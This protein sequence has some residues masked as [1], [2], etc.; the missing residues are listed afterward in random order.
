MGQSEKLD[1]LIPQLYATLELPLVFDADALNALARTSHAFPAPAGPRVLTPHSGEF[2]RL[3]G[4]GTKPADRTRLAE[5]MADRLDVIMVLKGHRTLVTDGTRSFHN[6]TGNPGMATGGSG[7]V[8]TGIITAL[9]CQGL[10]PWDAACLGVHAH[11]LAGD[12]AAESC[13]QV[14]L[15]AT[16]IIEALCDVWPQVSE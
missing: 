16:D 14:A 1:R 15:T 2:D 4:S 5:E 7:D 12:M 8:L 6:T 13:S 10:S 11:G 9:L 3:A